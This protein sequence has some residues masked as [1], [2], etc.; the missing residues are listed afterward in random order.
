ME[1]ARRPVVVL[2]ALHQEAAALAERLSRADAAAGRLSVWSGELEGEALAVVLTGVGKVAAAAA[3]QAVCDGMRPLS[4]LSIGLAGAVASGTAQGAVIVA[5]AAIQH[6]FDARPLVRGR[7]WIPGFGE[8][9]FIA[10][11]GI[12]R[13]LAR[14]AASV[15]GPSRVGSGLVLTGDQIVSSGEV[16]DRIVRAFPEGACLDM[17]TAAVAQVACQNGIPWGG[18]RV[19][20]DSADE[21]FNLEHMLGFGTGTAAELFDRMI[22][23]F[24]MDE[25]R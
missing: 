15:V 22:R 10:D 1:A 12:G 16:R 24:L 20:S 14:A 25:E 21:S 13:R 4:I 18:V 8:G 7:G 5:T 17:E 11:A 19:I 9:P 6:D 2:A 3:T 23:A